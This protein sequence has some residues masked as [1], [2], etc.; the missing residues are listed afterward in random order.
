MHEPLALYLTDPRDIHVPDAELEA[1]LDPLERTRAA[2]FR[3]SRD[4]RLFRVSHA[5]L[6]LALSRHDGRPPQA[7][8]YNFG[9][10]GRPELDEPTPPL[11]FNLSHTRNG[12]AIAIASAGSL[13]V[14]IEDAERPRDLRAIADRFFAPTELE[15]LHTLDNDDAFRQRFFHLWT[16]KESYIK[17]R[18]DGLALPLDAFAF[19]LDPPHLHFH[20]EDPARI[21]NAHPHAWRFALLHAPSGHP[22]ALAFCPDS[23][24]V[25]P[26]PVR[27][28]TLSLEGAQP[29]QTQPVALAHLRLAGV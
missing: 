5:L 19:E 28:W 13:G 21:P 2:R 16:L 8:R 18:G 1:L 20:V 14:D 3:F 9:P 15:A 22:V 4:Q 25:E 27:T 29:L 24:I 10:R 6:R 7:W 26:T 11:R 12:I 23:S 17:A